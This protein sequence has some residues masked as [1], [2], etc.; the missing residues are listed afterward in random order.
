[1]HILLTTYG[2][3]LIFTLYAASQWRSATDMAFMDIVSTDVFALSRTRSLLELNNH[4]H[5]LFTKI[6]GKE[7]LKTKSIAKIDSTKQ[8]ETNALITEE[9]EEEPI[10]IREKPEEV[11]KTPKK[12]NPKQ[13]NLTSH[14]HI[15]ELFTSDELNI[16]EG[17]GK[18]IFTI[19][20]NMMSAMYSEEKF[21][22]EAKKAD[23]EFEEHFMLNL[24]EK[25]KETNKELGRVKDLGT[26]N[27]D[28]ELQNYVR[29]KIFKGNKTILSPNH[30]E[31]AGYYPFLEFTE[32]SKKQ[33][34]L[35]LWLARKPILM[36]LFQ[37]PE[38]VDEL[39]QVRRDAYY[40]LKN[41]KTTA[42]A[43]SQDLK[44]RFSQQLE[45]QGIDPKFIDFNVST[46][47]PY[48][49]PKTQKARS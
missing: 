38:V 47:R 7:K 32:M 17:K 37:K 2:L 13:P 36:A 22:K 20:K 23:P 29:Y 42:G 44:L 6:S 48:D 1:M 41:K 34:I 46:T 24:Y 43:I 11:E 8:A 15:G 49:M 14:L 12:I 30:E 16:Y 33:N 26:L 28:D 25:A 10:E 9:E 27:L 4:S 19:M 31:E 39:L 45:S 35:S 18:A 3:L 40:D 21:F 5:A